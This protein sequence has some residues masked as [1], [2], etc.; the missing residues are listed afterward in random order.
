MDVNI[1]MLIKIWM[2]IMEIKLCIISSGHF[3]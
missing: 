3:P 1:S 2:D